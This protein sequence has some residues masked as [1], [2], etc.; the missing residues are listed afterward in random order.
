M[1][2]WIILPDGYLGDVIISKKQ[3]NIK[4]KITAAAINI[5]SWL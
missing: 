5:L 1:G 3:K 4:I 2:N